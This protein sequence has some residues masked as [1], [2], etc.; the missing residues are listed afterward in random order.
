MKSGGK[1]SAV[2]L[3]RTD[4]SLGG[5]F[6]KLREVR[7]QHDPLASEEEDPRL[8]RVTE[9]QRRHVHPCTGGGSPGEVCDRCSVGAE[10][11]AVELAGREGA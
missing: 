8:D 2:P 9:R 7:V 11:R 1:R 6:V 3:D 4:Q 5:N 10:G